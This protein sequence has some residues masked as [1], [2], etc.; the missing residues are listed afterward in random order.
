MI[1]GPF[2]DCHPGMTQ[3]HAHI[4]STSLTAQVL[5]ALASAHCSTSSSQPASGAPGGG[6]QV[7]SGRS[8]GTTP[9][10]GGGEEEGRS[11]DASLP[12]LSTFLALPLAP[13]P[14]RRASV[15]RDAVR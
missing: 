8:L 4:Q 10:D 15:R 5:G 7:I 3:R 6:G 1:R 11:E 12:P 2:S 9:Y 14:C 13:M